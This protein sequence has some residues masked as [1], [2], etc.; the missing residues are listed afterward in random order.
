[1]I[2]DFQISCCMSVRWACLDWLES[3]RACA[4]GVGSSHLTTDRDDAG[5]AT[6][7]TSQY[8]YRRAF[9]Q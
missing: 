3:N 9:D 6:Y 7:L 4:E 2:S 8:S 1:M 5:I